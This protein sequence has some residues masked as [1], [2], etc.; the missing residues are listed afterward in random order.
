M[1]KNLIRS[2]LI[3]II[4]ATTIS[5]YA[6]P[7]IPRKYVEHPGW[8]IGVNFGLADLWGDVGTQGMID[9]YANEKYWSKPHFM[10]GLLFRYTA[11]PSLGIRFNVNYGTLYATDEWNITKAK[12]ANSIED[13]AYQR[14]LRNQDVRANVWE[15][16]FMVEL[17]PMRFNSESKIA[18]KSMQFYAT[19]GVGAFHFRPQTSLIHPVTGRKEWVWTKEL[20]L[21]GEG[22]EGSGAVASS[23]WQMCV[24]LGA[25]IRWDIGD[26]MGL[27]VEYLYRFTTTDRLDNV[28]SEYLTPD[29]FDRYLDPDDAAIAKRVYDKSWYIDPTYKNEPGSP[30]GNKEVLDGYSTFSIM[31]IYKF[32]SNKIPW[33]Y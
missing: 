24:P 4:S 19:A 1:R 18:Q 32:T 25:G 17:L 8:A 27:G 6:Q 22:I 16:S 29:Y 13:D 30:R 31:F 9:H 12:K 20:R 7:A 23:L 33:W 5:A 11:H 10:G 2:L 15:G 14:Y 3:V 28:S 26:N 21:E